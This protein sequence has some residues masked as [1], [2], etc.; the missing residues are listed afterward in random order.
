ML[1]EKTFV[2]QTEAA[3]GARP[4]GRQG[5]PLNTTITLLIAVPNWGFTGIQMGL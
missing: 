3:G 5:T 4:E 2:G 1:L